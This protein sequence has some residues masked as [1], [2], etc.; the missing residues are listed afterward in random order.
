MAHHSKVLRIE[1]LSPDT[2]RGDLAVIFA[3]CG[4]I[5]NIRMVEKE[6]KMAFIDFKTLKG[7]ETALS[8][9]KVE[10]KGRTL[11][12]YDAGGIDNP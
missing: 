12:L 2:T 6:E 3:S 5:T 7:V 9:T 11:K 10:L 1:N 4:A 8:L